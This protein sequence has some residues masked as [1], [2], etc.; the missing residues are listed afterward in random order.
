LYR[1]FYVVCAMKTVPRC[2]IC[3]WPL[4]RNIRHGISVCTWLENFRVYVNMSTRET[5][6][7]P[8]GNSL[9]YRTIAC[10]YV[11]IRAIAYYMKYT[12]YNVTTC[13]LCLLLFICIVLIIKCYHFCA[14]PKIIKCYHLCFSILVFENQIRYVLTKS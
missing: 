1:D 11:R 4:C 2:K 3:V 8:S 14:S 7:Q 13:I 9:R 10:R 5:A 6:V 12:N